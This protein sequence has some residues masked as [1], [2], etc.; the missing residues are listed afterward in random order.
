MHGE[1]SLDAERNWGG[2]KQTKQNSKAVCD[3]IVGFIQKVEKHF[4]ISGN[5]LSHMHSPEYS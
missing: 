5:L 4:F 2:K 1:L 3:S